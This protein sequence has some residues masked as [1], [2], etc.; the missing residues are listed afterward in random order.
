M[1]VRD[2]KWQPTAKADSVWRTLSRQSFR[3]EGKRNVS[4]T[5]SKSP[6]KLCTSTP[7]LGRQS[8][9]QDRPTLVTTGARAAKNGVGF[10]PHGPPVVTKVGRRRTA[11][12]QR[13]HAKRKARADSTNTTAPTHSCSMCGLGLASLAIYRPTAVSLQSKVMVIFD[14]FS[15][16][17][18]HKWNSDWVHFN[19]LSR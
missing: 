3:L 15:K 9:A 5:A 4:K 16:D 14:F 17:E 11:E 8:L 2:Y 7:V 19:L 18:K 12:A 10:L 6:T 1:T 13:K